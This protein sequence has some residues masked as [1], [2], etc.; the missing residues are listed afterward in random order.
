MKINF[1]ILMTLCVLVFSYCSKQPAKTYEIGEEAFGG[2]VIQIDATG[3]HGLVV[4][5]KDQV[6]TSPSMN[7]YESLDVIASFNEGGEGWRMPNKDELITMYSMKHSIGNFRNSIYWSSTKSGSLNYA[8][9]F[10]NGFTQT[11]CNN[12]SGHCSRAVKDF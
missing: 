9:F 12:V 4:A 3:E 11:V 10:G 8:I 1:L 6:T 5:K 7:Y 2:I